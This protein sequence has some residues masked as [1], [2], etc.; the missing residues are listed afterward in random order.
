MSA[1]IV[2]TSTLG[3]RPR[4]VNNLNG[5]SFQQD[6]LVTYNSMRRPRSA[7]TLDWQYCA[8]YI[9]HVEG[10]RHVQL[11]RRRVPSLEW[12]SI[13]FTDYTQIEDDGH[14]VICIG[15]SHED[16]SFHLSWDLHSSQF[17]YR[18]SLVDLVSD[19]EHARWAIESFG[20]VLHALPGLEQDMSEVSRLE[21]LQ[22]RGR[23]PTRGSC[24]YPKH[25][26]ERYYSM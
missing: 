25:R 23:L 21:F 15:I 18:R 5:E 16:G 19:P 22:L 3:Q 12:D 4:A 10:Q 8:L 2:S 26:E 17:N 1:R 11:S 13:V 24:L 9:D 6:V 14:N 7:L 20:P